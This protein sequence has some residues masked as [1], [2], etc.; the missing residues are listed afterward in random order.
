MYLNPFARNTLPGIEDARSPIQTA[1]PFAFGKLPDTF[2]IELW[3]AQDERYKDYWAWFRGDILN[4]TVGKTADNEPVYRYPLQIN[5]V[6]NFSRKHAALLFGEIPDTPS[7]L[8]KTIIHPK[9]ALSTGKMIESRKDDATFYANIVNEI[10]NASSGRGIQL[11]NGF[12]SQFLGGCVFQIMYQPWRTDLEIPIVVKNWPVDFFLP[13]WSGDNP[14]EL[15]EAYIVCRKPASQVALEYGIVTENSP[16]VTYYEH[17]TAKTHTI[18]IDNKPLTATFKNGRTVTY[19]NAPHDL[20]FV[21][22][23]YIPRI[24]EG[25]YYGSSMVEDMR[26]LVRELNA[27]MSDAGSAILESAHRT[28]IAKNLSGTPKIKKLANGQEYVDLGQSNPAFGTDPEFAPADPPQWSE[29]MNSFNDEIYEQLRRVSSIS[30]IAEGQDEG[31]QRSALTLAFRMWPSTALAKAQRTF[32][33]D[34]LNHMAKQ[35]LRI[36]AT[37]KVKIEAKMVPLDFERKVEFSQDWLPMVPRDREQQV[38]E[39]VL[40]SQ[41]GLISPQR[42]MEVLGDIRDEE[43]EFQLIKDWMLFQA[44]LAAA[45]AA[46]GS[47]DAKGA[48]GSPAKFGMGATEVLSEPKASSGLKEGI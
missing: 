6:R 47:P 4:E 14:W 32:W 27:R 36:C 16:Y 29:T 8:V 5:P 26:G 19:D 48:P 30:S 18:L 43:E 10:W 45:T 22:F 40:L 41:S 39:V 33:E 21:P 11:E 31:S 3:N 38:N 15:L 44:Q 13:I 23:T 37:Q 34:G 25:N 17:W 24:R 12:L 20:G 35:M 46:A 42:A 1:A 2:P 7:P 28:W 9:K